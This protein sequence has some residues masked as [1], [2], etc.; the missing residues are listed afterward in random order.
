[1]KQKIIILLVLTLLLSCG[2]S[3]AQQLLDQI[4][5]VVENETITQRELMSNLILVR[6]MMAQKDQAIPDE[7]VLA[8]QVLQQTITRKLQLQE[9]AKL[10][11]KIDEITLDRTLTN[12]AQ[13]NKI[14]LTELKQQLEQRGQS[15]ESAR[16]KIREDLT[17]QRV[18]QREVIDRINVSEQEIKD[19]LIAKSDALDEKLGYH[20]AYFILRPPKE[21]QLPR[22]IQAKILK[23]HK[24]LNKENINN[25]SMLKKRIA[26]LWDETKEQKNKSDAPIPNYRLT[27]MGWKTPEELPTPLQK[28]LYTLSTGEQLL[29]ISNS[30]GIHLFHLLEIQ[31][32]DQTVMQKKYHIRHILMQETPLDDATVI[33]TKLKKIK[34]SA[35][36]NDNFAEAAR[37][38]SQDPGSAYKG[39]DLDWSTLENF[40]PAFAEAAMT[41]SQEGGIFGPFKSGFG[42]HLLEVVGV[43][44]ENISNQ[45]TREIAISQIK[46]KRLNDEIRLWLLKLREERH[47][48][49]L[50]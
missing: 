49:V 39:G 35:E 13:K 9:A 2:T 36:K 44:E 32:G 25:F 30:R 8:A 38:Y 23:I 31:S 40:D 29:P 24:I 50:L 7:K 46:K 26:E 45:A 3:T 21:G 48:E 6:Q 28:R 41:A 27:D 4:V 37:Q 20:F 42:W 43:R 15:F 5:A 22:A 1:M 11:I 18:M 19:F 14:T 16:E 33:K 34:R 12:I 47:I 10:G 17:I